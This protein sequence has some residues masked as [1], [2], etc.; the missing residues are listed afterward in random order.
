MNIYLEDTEVEKVF[1]ITQN[2]LFQQKW[3]AWLRK[4]MIMKLEIKFYKINLKILIIL[5]S[6]YL[7]IGSGS[8]ANEY[9]ESILRP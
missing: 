6:K 1:E 2:D 8:G 5:I 7:D 4:F 3:V 9:F